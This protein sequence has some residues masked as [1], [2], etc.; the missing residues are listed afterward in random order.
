MKNNNKHIF[1]FLSITIIIS[2]ILNYF[3]IKSGGLKSAGEILII[4]IMWTPGIAALLTLII[5]KQSLKKILWK[6]GKPKYLLQAYY[7]PLI[8]ISAAYLPLWLFGYY[9]SNKQLTIQSILIPL[10]G[11]FINIIATLG[12]E[13]GWRGFLFPE[14]EKKNEL[15]KSCY[16]NWIYMGNLAYPWIIND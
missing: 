16:I 12:E 4:S 3:I 1:A 14:L 11:A 7:I 9:D 15:Y 13:I 6:I 5:F 10:F 8:Y 2:A